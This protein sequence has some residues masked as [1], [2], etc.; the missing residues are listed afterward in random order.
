MPLKNTARHATTRQSTTHH[1]TQTFPG[2]TAPGLAWVTGNDAPKHGTSLRYI[3]RHITPQHSTGP[4]PVSPTGDFGMRPHSTAHHATPRH[5]TPQHNTG[6]MPQSKRLRDAAA[7]A[8]TAQHIISQPVTT[9]RPKSHHNTDPMP[10]R[11]RSGMRP[12]PP[13]CTT[14]YRTATHNTP[15]HATTPHQPK[16]PNHDRH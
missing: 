4:I 6:S 16:E 5:I 10:E 7:S 9:P 11:S 15:L 8:D 13:H 12:H 2:A 1:V 14:H 3:P